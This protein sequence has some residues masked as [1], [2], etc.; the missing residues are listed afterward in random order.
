MT[1]STKD[2]VEEAAKR[3]STYMKKG[4]PGDWGMDLEV[5]DWTP[6]VGVIA[7]LD[8]YEQTK[9]QELLDDLIAWTKRNLHQAEHAKVI[10]SMAPFTIFP[11]L[12]ELTGEQVY[13][14]FSIRI[15][16]WMLYEAPRTRE[17]AFEHT[18][19]EAAKFPEQ[20]WA[21]TVFM[22]VL[23]L[24]RLGRV[25]SDLRFS[26]EALK[27]LTLHIQLLQDEKTGL[28]FHGW[29][30]G[31]ANHMSAARWGRANAWVA[32]GALM[33][34]DELEGQLD[35]PHALRD[36]YITLLHGLK[37]VQHSNG[38]WSV[39]LDKPEYRTE[40]S[41]SAGIA[42]GF[43]K[44]VKRGWVDASFAAAADRTLQAVLNEIDQEGMVHGVSGGTPVLAT[45]EEYNGFACFPT[46][47]GQGLVLLLLGQ[48]IS[49]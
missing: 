20:V 16:E 41:G 38:L 8:Y 40:V 48:Y 37:N 6:G 42:A 27:Q 9:Q 29:D 11:R 21:D 39:V 36:Q 28:L 5:W 2:R 47:Y 26:E 25:S 34:F 17:D 46:L 7:L 35:I 44:A 33:I 15:G 31:A 19:T 24:A 43:S 3:I 10:N 12:Y 1:I 45:E 32:V 49:A 13:L 14:N 4:A 30:C 22:A 23:F 18:V